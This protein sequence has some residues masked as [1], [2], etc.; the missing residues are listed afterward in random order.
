MARNLAGFGTQFKWYHWVGG[1]T[2]G[3]A[4]NGV[5][6]L[7]IG[8]TYRW[9]WS[10][11]E[12]RVNTLAERLGRPTEAQRLEIFDFMA[13]NW[14]KS[15]AIVEQGGAKKYKDELF[16]SARGD[17]LEVGVGT[18]QLFEPLQ[19]G[20]VKSFVG[21]DAV[22]A[23]LEQ[24]RAK[25]EALSLP[26]S[27]QLLR[28]DAHKMPFPDNTFDTVVG[29]LC[30]CSMERPADVLYEM[31]RVCKPGGLILLVEP[32]LATYLPVRMGQ[33]YIGLVPDPRH[34]WEYGWRDDLDVEQLVR[35]CASLK[36]L[37]VKARAICGNWY[38]VTATPKKKR[39]FQQFQVNAKSDGS[40]V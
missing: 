3:L 33:R 6:L 34:A 35:A 20:K 1:A 32:G 2:T 17:V 22:E 30:L 24:A 13:P 14:D 7:G 36:V 25:V 27:T 5:V 15:M 9:Y 31:S 8:E 39:E 26:F 28:A 23:M 29:S 18:G 10:D 4:I 40:P 37:S 11:W 19:E 12:K 21:I 16:K 38:Q